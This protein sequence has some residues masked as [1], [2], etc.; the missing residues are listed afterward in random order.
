MTFDRTRAIA[1]YI[2]TNAALPSVPADLRA[3][4]L[5]KFPE[6]STDELYA[7]YRRLTI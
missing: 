3:D 6:P 1:K 2:A 5:S 7:G 4:F